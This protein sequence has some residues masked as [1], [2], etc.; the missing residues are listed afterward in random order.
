MFKKVVIG[1]SGGVDSAVSALLLKNKGFNL[2]GVFMKN[3]D[4]TDETG[5][6][7]SESDWIDAQWICDRLEIPIQRVDFVKEYWNDVFEYLSSLPVLER[8]N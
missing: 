4:I 6:C 5:Y 7:S 8:R 1:I 3:W 2:H